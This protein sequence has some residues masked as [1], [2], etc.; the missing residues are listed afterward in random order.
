MSGSYYSNSVIGFLND[1]KDRI[2]GIL[3]NRP[4]TQATGRQ[5]KAWDETIKILQNQL[6]GMQD[7][8]IL[9]EYTIP[10]M[11]RRV[12]A[13]LLH[14]NIVFVMEFKCGDMEYASH[15]IDQV[16]GYVQDLKNFQ[17]ESE[18]KLLVPIIIPTKAQP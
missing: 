11:G 9:L 7:G 18:D 1:D 13:V 15:T 17:K 8:R 16:Y 5:I 4:D 2:C 6:A 3:T 14:N 12:D 10:R